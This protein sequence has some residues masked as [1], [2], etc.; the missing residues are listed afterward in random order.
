MEN[1][2]KN[3]S[4]IA[5]LA[6]AALA[7]TAAAQEA[8]G[9]NWA[10]PADAQA[11]NAGIAAVKADAPQTPPATPAPPTPTTPPPAA[12]V[13][14][15]Q[16]LL[17]RSAA[18]LEVM[19][20]SKAPGPVP[21]GPAQGYASTSPGTDGGSDSEKFFSVLWQ[22]KIFDRTGD[23]TANLVNQTLIGKSFAAEV[24][25]GKSLLDG[26]D[27]IIIDYKNTPFLPFRLIRDEIRQVGPGVYLGYAYLRGIDKAPILFSL[28]FNQQSPAK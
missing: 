4:I 25:I 22:G 14:T 16:Q 17:T 5:A 15:A 24:Y 2:M 3:T 20:R 18:D 19:Y 10:K 7:R 23:Q 1:I 28:D 9:T 8:S 6:L 26:K 11:I 13:T 27:A 21:N 12:P